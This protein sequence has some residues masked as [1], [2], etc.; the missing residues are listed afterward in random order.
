MY[1]PSN[2]VRI[3]PDTA[4]SIFWGS[5][6]SSAP[7]MTSTSSARW[8]AVAIV[9]TD[10][11]AGWLPRVETRRVVRVARAQKGGCGHS[12]WAAIKVVTMY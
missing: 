6:T 3:L 10:A 8:V 11:A 9:A 5:V 2:D 4:E 12:P 1:V 7:W